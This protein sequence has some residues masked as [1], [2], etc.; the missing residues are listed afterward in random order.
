MT[1]DNRDDG[2][3]AIR[4]IGGVGRVVVKADGLAAGKGVVVARDHIE[5]IAALDEMLVGHTLGDAGNVMVIEECLQGPEVSILSVTDGTTVYPLAPSC[6]Y[7][8]AYDNDEGPNT[9]GMGAYSPTTLVDDALM[10]EI[11]ET[12]LQ[13]TIDEMARRGTPMV[14]V[15][16][17]GL[18]LTADGPKVLE[19]NCRFGDPETQV[20][21]PTLRSDLGVLLEAVANGTLADV[22][23]PVASG[24]AVGVILASGGYPGPYPKG[25]PISGL[26]TTREGVLV[27]QAGTARDDNGQTV[28]SGGRVLSVVGLPDTIAGAR[29]RAYAAADKITFE[30]VMRREDIALREA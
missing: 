5:A 6:D 16:Y 22:P 30:G 17:A 27:F 9:G 20:V 28:T 14:G 13:P 12:I 4:E 8:R 24:A 3:T 29:D 15:L 1:V 2:V 7:K 10:R 26:D 21:L 23:E 11:R 19:F 18:I 25:L